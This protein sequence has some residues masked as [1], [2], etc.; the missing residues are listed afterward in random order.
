MNQANAKGRNLL[1]AMKPL[2]NPTGAERLA[3]ESCVACGA[4]KSNENGVVGRRKRLPHDGDIKARE[5][6]HTFVS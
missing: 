1:A 2:K 3:R 5:L 6:P 4:P